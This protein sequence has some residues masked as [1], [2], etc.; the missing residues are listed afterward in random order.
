MDPDRCMEAVLGIA[1]VELVCSVHL[2]SMS[3][4]VSLRRAT[5]S[6]K[7]GL[8]NASDLL[9]SAIDRDFWLPCVA[10]HC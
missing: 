6:E 9:Q 4:F 2:D 10:T 3:R 1:R 5:A 8:T 7:V